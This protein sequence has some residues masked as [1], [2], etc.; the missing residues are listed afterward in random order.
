M[1]FSRSTL[2][3][4]ANLLRQVQIP[5]TDPDLVKNAEVVALARDELEAA[6][7]ELPVVLPVAS[8]P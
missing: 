8:D 7:R 1:E 6:G 3:L 2:E 5:A 4:F